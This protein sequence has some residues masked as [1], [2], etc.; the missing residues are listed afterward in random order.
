[1]SRIGRTPIPVPANVQ[2]HWTENNLVTI[3]GPKGEL[4]YQ[5]DPALQLKLEN[6]ILSVARPSDSKEHKAK[7]GLY[8][9]LI[10]NMVV[11]VTNGYTKQLEIHGV[12]Y[13]AVKVGENLVIQVGYSHPIE[14]QS[15]KG[16]VLNVDGVDPATKATKLS[17]SGIDKQLVGEVAA[18]IRQIRKPEPYKGKGIRYVGEAVRRKAGKAGK[19]GGKKK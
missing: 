17:V 14:V 16:I 6:G 1:M 8:R 13:R 3:K 4:S 15:P 2:V 9:T 12:G 19:V 10:N 18:T 11:G 7:H 5:V